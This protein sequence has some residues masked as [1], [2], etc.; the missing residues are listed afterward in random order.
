MHSG[1]GLSCSATVET[2][3]GV[4][5]MAGMTQWGCLSGA[6]VLTFGWVPQ[7]SFT[8]QMLGWECWLLCSCAGCLGW[9]G[10]SSWELVGH[11]SPG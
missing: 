6:V 8:W 9:D 11:L 2:S 1:N 3:A 5:M 4:A 10:W 7:L